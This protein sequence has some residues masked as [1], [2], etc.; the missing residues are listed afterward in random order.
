MY[1]YIKKYGDGSNNPY[2]DLKTEDDKYIYLTLVI[3][4]AKKITDF[5]DKILDLYEHGN[6]EYC[7]DEL[8][9]LS[10]RFDDYASWPQPSEITINNIEYKHYLF[11]NIYPKEFDD[12]VDISIGDYDFPEEIEFPEIPDHIDV[13]ENWAIDQLNSHEMGEPDNPNAITFLDFKYFSK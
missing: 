11:E 12:T 10:V 2:K 13:D 3:E 5:W 9:N 4:E 6:M 1:T 7:I 8:K